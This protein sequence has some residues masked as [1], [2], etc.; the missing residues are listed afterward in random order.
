MEVLSAPIAS[1]A[2]GLTTLEKMLPPVEMRSIAERARLQKACF[3]ASLSPWIGCASLAGD[4]VG[5]GG[6]FSEAEGCVLVGKEC[7]GLCLF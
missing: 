7:P 1:E 6:W 3:F 4:K 2:A 5:H